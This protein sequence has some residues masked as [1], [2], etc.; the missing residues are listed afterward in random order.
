MMDA[1][2]ATCWNAGF[3]SMAKSFDLLMRETGHLGGVLLEGDEKAKIAYLQSL[4]SKAVGEADWVAEREERERARPYFSDTGKDHGLTGQG[5]GRSIDGVVSSASGPTHS[6]LILDPKLVENT[7]LKIVQENAAA[8]PGDVDP[9]LVEWWDRRCEWAVAGSLHCAD[10]RTEGLIQQALDAHA[11]VGVKER[12]DKQVALA[13]LPDTYLEEVLKSPGSV[14]ARPHTKRNE[15]GGKLRAIYGVNLE[16]Y[17][18]ASAVCSV[19]EQLT[20]GGLSSSPA[21]LTAS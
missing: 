8:K 16:H 2:L 15:L 20:A 21:Q 5:S 18:V 10:G 17:V 4:S 11:G 13:T 1:A 9:T 7:V 12:P 19:I 6:G 14:Y 3:P